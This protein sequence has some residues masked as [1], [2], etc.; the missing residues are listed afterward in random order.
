ML[1]YKY[2]DG[3]VPNSIAFSY[4]FVGYPL[5]ILG[6]LDH[7]LWPL[8]CI[9]LAHILIIAAYLFHECAHNTVFKSV[10]QNARVGKWLSFITGASYTSYQQ[11][12]EKHFKHHVQR[13]DVLA[14]NTHSLLE[15]HPSLAKLVRVLT[16]F[17]IPALD[18]LSQYL[19]LLAPFIL[20]DM[21]NQKGHVISMLLIRACLFLMLTML[22]LKAAMLYLLAWLIMTSVLG[23]M[24]A[25]Q[26]T[27]QINYNLFKPEQSVNFDAVYEEKNTYSNLLSVK[28]PWINL[29]VLNFC[30]HNAHHHKPNAPWYRLP[31]I[32]KQYYPNGCEQFLPLKE[33]L[34]RYH[35]YRFLRLKPNEQIAASGIDGVNFLVGV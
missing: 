20:P 12:R 6:L 32:H 23:F 1:K 3:I 22:S 10:E 33:L 29:L 34:H 5:A 13:E 25:F 7:F 35:Q 4:V 18:V 2:R 24:D 31:D 8:A 26:H 19:A 9:W 28:H 27:Y 17:H 15:K 21:H 16:F 11:L 30:Y 14:I